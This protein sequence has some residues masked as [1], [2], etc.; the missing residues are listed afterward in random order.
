MPFVRI[1]LK[2]GKS[3]SFKQ[4]ISQSIH[5]SLT[6]VFG[7]PEDDMF[8]VIEEVPAENII[9]PP[10]YMG[11]PHTDEI[12]YIVITAKS[13]RSV[14]MKKKLY[15]TIADSIYNTTQHPKSDVFIVMVENSEENWSFGDGLAQLV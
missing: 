14:E 7:I 8:Q 13:G 15:H 2:E 9:Y 3:S 5:A 12:I 4:S 11:I 6:K 1:S 10:S